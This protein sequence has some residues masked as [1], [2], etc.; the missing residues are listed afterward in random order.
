MNL[1]KK[2][3]IL[4]VFF[5]FVRHQLGRHWETVIMFVPT[6]NGMCPLPKRQMDWIAWGRRYT[7]PE[8]QVSMC[9]LVPEA[10]WNH[11]L[12]LTWK[13]T[14]CFLKTLHWTLH[15]VCVCVCVVSEIG[16]T[17]GMSH[18]G[19][20]WAEWSHDRELIR[21]E[22]APQIDPLSTWPPKRLQ[23]LTYLHQGTVTYRAEDEVA[24]QMILQSNI[25]NGI[26]EHRNQGKIAGCCMQKTLMR[27]HIKT[28]EDLETTIHDRS[29]LSSF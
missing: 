18:W 3:I 26:T 7:H 8:I 9:G 14:S 4:D 25:S 24:N 6:V 20:A 12:V 27:S 29:P 5:L 21:R 13:I 16:V 19:S 10:E 11:R 15:Y 28:T 2:L 17:L 1:G 23:W 22:E